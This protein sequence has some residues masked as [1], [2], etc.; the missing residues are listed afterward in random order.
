VILVLVAVPTGVRTIFATAGT[1]PLTRL[2][3]EVIG[4]Q[5]WWE[6]KY[7]NWRS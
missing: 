6:Y 1:R 7:P 2:K 3:V 4:H 5:W